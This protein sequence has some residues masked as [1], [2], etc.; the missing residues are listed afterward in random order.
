MQTT[1][2]IVAPA[3]L[4]KYGKAENMGIGPQIRMRTANND[5]GNFPGLETKIRV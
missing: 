4:G 5:S 2:L 1:F 3:M